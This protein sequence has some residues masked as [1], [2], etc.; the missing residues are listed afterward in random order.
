[1]RNKHYDVVVVGCGPG[2]AIAGKFA[3]LNGAETLVIEEKRQIGFPL[4][5][6]FSI[7]YSK[8]EIEE[9]TEEEVEPAVI[10][11]KVEGLAYVSPKGKRGKPQMLT[12]AILID[13]PLLEKSLAMGAI[14][15]G[16]EIMLH[17]R[18]IDLVIESGVVRGVIVRD[19]SE[20][21]SVSCS[22]VIAADGCDRIIPRLAGM[23]FTS[24]PASGSLGYDFVG[25]KPLGRP[26]NVV[27]IYLDDSGEGRYKYVTPHG[28]DRFFVGSVI[29]LAAVIQ[30]KSLKQRLDEFVRH[31][32]AIGRYDFSKASPVSMNSGSTVRAKLS[33]LASDGVIT[34]GNSAGPLLFGNRWGA[35]P[36]IPGACWTGR[37]A[38]EIAASAVK[39]GDVSGRALDKKYRDIIDESLKG[40]GAHVS[41]ALGLW[42][43]VFC[44]NSEEQ[45][46][47]VEEIGQEVAAMHLYSKGALPLAFCR[48]PVQDWLRERRGG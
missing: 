2:G 6:S 28:E 31:L 10:H 46:R 30:K 24:E 34:V 48:E 36:L 41:E 17:T 45:E 18:V 19:R 43:Q 16:A 14:R 13:R 27:E 25:V 39:K 47:V 29:S 4:F 35:A 20:L 40:E 7:L 8:S 1:M 23:G 15:A 5:D 37:V 12:D 38:G 21:K 9:T 42:R 26:N 22:L 11:S 3:A 32:E 33:M 44:L